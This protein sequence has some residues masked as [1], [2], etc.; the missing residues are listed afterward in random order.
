MK[1]FAIIV[2]AYG[3]AKNY[4]Y[5]FNQKGIGCIHIQ[6]TL[7]PISALSKFSPDDYLYN[8]VH[9]GNLDDTLKKVKSAEEKLN[10]KVVSVI[11]GIEPGVLLADL[12]S[13]RMQLITNGTLLSS[14]RRDKY[15]MAKELQ[16]KGIEVPD[17]LKSNK[18]VDITSWVEKRNEFPVV[19]KPLDSAGSDGVYICNDIEDVIKACNA[20][21]GKGNILGKMNDYVLIQSFLKGKEYVINT[22]SCSGHHFVSDMW[23]SSKTLLDGY[24]F[25]YDKEEI[26]SLDT[27]IAHQITS[28]CYSVLDA[29][30]IKFG[31]AHIE[32][33]MT[34]AGPALIE[35]GARMGGGVNT[36]VTDFC[37]G[38][39][40][41]ELTVDSYVD[42]DS[43]FSKTSKK[44]EL[45]NHGIMM[46]LSSDKEGEITDIPLMS[47]LEGFET[48]VNVNI[49]VKV[50]D[51]LKKTVD[52]NSSP[53]N[54][55]LAHK[56]RNKIQE[57]YNKI[58]L[59]AKDGFVI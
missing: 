29:L 28:Y 38:H 24:G 14:A 51:R 8:I 18:I 49:R 2:D 23:I 58:K 46:L 26:I 5:Y 20:N 41:V 13:E 43:F 55:H 35:I 59:L 52:L 47:H 40:Q 32:L 25:I 31:P 36:R 15:L 19:I 34:E 9:D 56:D 3:P 16:K 11:A 4:I 12:L 42:P 37:V 50:G 30:G 27:E 7:D 21:I 39:N 6:S 22:V 44:Y 33:M 48:I 1:K 17:F 53:G 10:G 57:E 45:K 54:F